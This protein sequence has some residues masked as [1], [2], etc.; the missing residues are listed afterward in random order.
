MLFPVF[1]AQCNFFLP[2][3]QDAD[4]NLEPILSRSW[5]TVFA[6]SLGAH[7]CL[8][9][10]NRLRAD[11]LVLIAPFLDF[12]QGTSAEK[13]KDMLRS[14][15]NNPQATVR[16]FWKACAVKQ[17]PKPPVD[18]AHALKKGLELLIHSRVEQSSLATHLPVTLIHGLADRIVPPATS[19][20]IKSCLP[21]ACCRYVPYGHYIPEPEILNAIQ[22]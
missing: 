14:L 19:E 4:E 2:L 22:Q 16:W 11:R 15:D 8:K 5:K 10:L 1:S 9:H 13:I 3:I 6:W 12:C 7:L 20:N 21:R 17:P 18:Q